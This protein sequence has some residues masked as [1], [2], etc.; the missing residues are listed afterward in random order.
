MADS[1]FEY[2]VDG[3]TAL[4]GGRRRV[5]LGIA[6]APGAGKSTLA[7]ALVTAVAE[8]QGP[9]W[10]AHVPMD[11]FHLADVQLDRLGLRHRKGAPETFDADGYAHLLR[12]LVEEPDTWIYAPG[13]ERTL[14]QPLAAAM[15]VPPA[16]RLVVTE[17]NYLLLPE[18]RWEAARAPLSQV[19]FV[20]LDDLVRRQRLVAR[21]IAFGKEPDAA[22]RWVAASDDPN[23]ALVAPTAASA[24]RLVLH[25]THGWQLGPGHAPEDAVC[26]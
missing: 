15:V 13:F 25:S 12:R 18:P 14:E 21:H 6:G 10:V 8:R 1:G 2:V 9:D 26:R 17:G 20:V 16:A 23:A 7:A 24:D 3:A 22:D 19:W 4:V 5:L 11:G